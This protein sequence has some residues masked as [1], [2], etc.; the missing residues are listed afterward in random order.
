MSGG[1]GN[2]GGGAGRFKDGSEKLTFA[3]AARHSWRGVRLLHRL[4]P[5]DLTL[6]AAGHALQGLAPMLALL[7]SSLIISEL[8][9]GRD[10]Q[11]IAALAAA[12]LAQGFLFSAAGRLIE[13]A[14]AARGGG[15]F[16]E[17]EN[18]ARQARYAGMD[19]ALVEDAG[20][21]A[22]AADI[23]VKT[24]IGLG[25]ARLRAAAPQLASGAVSLAASAALLAGL[26][27]PGGGGGG[28]IASPWA[29]ALLLASSIAVPA[30]LQIL[31]QKRLNRLLLSYVGG[32]SKCATLATYLANT[33]VFP[34]SG[35]KDVR[36]FKFQEPILDAI[37]KSQGWF[38]S[39]YSDA[40]CQSSGAGAAVGAAFGALAFLVIG[41]RALGGLHD[42][43][44][45]VRLVGAVGAFAAA[46]SG[47]LRLLAGMWENAPYL[48][49]LY[50]YLDLPDA[51]RRGTLTTEKRSD[52]QYE[53]EFRGVSFRYPGAES[54]ALRDINLA[55][56]PGERLAVV[57]MNGSGKTTMVKLL[58][59]LHEPTEGS[60]TLNGIDIWKYDY[61]EYI[62]IFAVAFQDFRLLGLPLGQNVA[63]A[64]GYDRG[65]ARAALEKT[66]FGARLERLEL[67]LDAPLSI[68]YDEGG[69]HVSGGE[70]Q[71]IALARAAYK[72]APFVILDEPTA[73]LDPIAE[74]EV[75]SRFNDIIGGKT[76]VF[77]SHRLS[78]CRFCHDIAVFHEGRIAQRGSHE[79]LLADRGGK[80][81]EL[82]LAQARHYAEGTGGQA[83]GAE[84]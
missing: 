11:R 84:G 35:G 38:R 64:A 47:A 7:F 40:A 65:L 50:D 56:A 70:A 13:Y 15:D 80:Y 10:P 52:G 59:R 55:F 44:E 74:H 4:Q 67:G 5:G 57:G 37:K 82:W 42:V 58:C 69:A 73:A 62:A 22:L 27:A 81:R 8:A 16:A 83:E 79:A 75:Y 46:A 14:A 72:D 78:S 36:I 48:G 26:F 34:H 76:A 41:L 25:L 49:M 3:Q 28:P 12:A 53:L 33:F 45:A 18:L 30:A 77:V 32:L 9:G 71:K 54:W 43:G 2:G 31:M 66:G 68:D 19:Y 6:S 20:A 51:A 39:G 60:I 29:M 63:A 17:R 21:N 23:R 61:D 1:N 24:D